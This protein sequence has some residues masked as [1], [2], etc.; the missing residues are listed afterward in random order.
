VTESRASWRP[1]DLE[2]LGLQ[3]EMVVDDRRRLAGV[4]GA[5]IGVAPNGQI[6]VV[7]SEVSD[8]LADEIREAVA[9]AP[10]ASAPD[11]EPPA[12]AACRAILEPACAPLTV[13]GGPYYVFDPGVRSEGCGPVVRSDAPPDE[14]LR[15]LNPGNWR[16]GEWDDL[17]DRD[18]GPWAML[19]LDDRVVSICH[20]PRPMTERAA[21]CGVWTDPAYRGRGYAAEVTATWADILRPSR[22]FLFYSTDAA[23]LS[24]QRVAARLELRP[25]GWTWKVMRDTGRLSDSRHPLRRSSRG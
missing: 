17:L 12:L 9:N 22:R 3:A 16:P 5:T 19:L 6:V 20:T 10:L 8:R 4:C 7:G 13:R 25:I 24:S 21:E 15:R 14:R 23:N 2:L 11:I 1:T 18:L